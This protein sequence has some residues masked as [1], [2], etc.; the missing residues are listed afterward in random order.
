ML[1][2]LVVLTNVAPLET[3]V[4]KKSAVVDPAAMTRSVRMV[5]FVVM[6]NV[7]QACAAVL[8]IFVVAVYVTKRQLIV[9]PKTRIHL[10]WTL[11]I[12]SIMGLHCLNKSGFCLAA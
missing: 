7:V 11:P 12:L 8:I 2:I 3:S 5:R 4:V 1:L 9:I 6:A 10:R